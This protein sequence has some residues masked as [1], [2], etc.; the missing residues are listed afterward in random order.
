[1]DERFCGL[2]LRTEVMETSR[3]HMYTMYVYIYICIH[4]KAADHK[5]KKRTRKLHEP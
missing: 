1:M 3:K 2:I 5:Q 4:L